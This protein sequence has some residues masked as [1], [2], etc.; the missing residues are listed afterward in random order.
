MQNLIQHC[1]SVFLPQC[2]ASDHRRA[3]SKPWQQQSVT[4]KCTNLSCN[5]LSTHCKIDGSNLVSW[6]QR[7]EDKLRTCQS[8]VLQ[9]QCLLTDPKVSTNTEFINTGELFPQ[10][11]QA[12]TRPLH[13]SVHTGGPPPSVVR[14]ILINFKNFASHPSLPKVLSC[15]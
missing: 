14:Q 10:R 6:E 11:Q 1:I 13:P 4:G 3:E 7:N 15:T 9:K 2:K 12:L 5:E 8:N